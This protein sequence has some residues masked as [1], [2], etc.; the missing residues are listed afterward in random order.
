VV[1]RAIEQLFVERAHFLRTTELGDAGADPLPEMA[2]LQLRHGSFA[3][4]LF[5]DLAIAMTF[6]P[7]LIVQIMLEEG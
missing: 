1:I 3:R 6:S 2:R 5:C 4:K 7:A